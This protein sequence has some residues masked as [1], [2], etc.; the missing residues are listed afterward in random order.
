MYA[1]FAALGLLA[2][3]SGLDNGL[4]R[5]PPIGWLNWERYR[6]NTNCKDDPNNCINADLFLTMAKHMAYDGY[7]DVGYEYVNIDDCW[8]ERKRDA[9]NQLVSNPDLFPNGVK[10]L[11][12]E[13]HDLGLK[14]GIY[15]DYGTHTC[16][17]YPGSR[18]HV[19]DDANLFASWGIDSLKLDGCY[20]NVTE[21]PTGYPEFTVA[22]NKTGRPIL[23][24]CSWPAYLRNKDTVPYGAIAENCNLWRNYGDIADSWGSVNAIANW[25]G[26]NAGDLAS[27][28]APGAW[29]D[30]DMLIIGD[31][32]LSQ[33]QS[34]AQMALWSIMAAPLYMSNDLRNIQ[35]WQ[36]DILQNQEVIMVDQDPLGIQGRRIY[37]AKNKQFEI[38]TRQLERGDMAICFFRKDGNGFPKHFSA[39]FETLGI[40]AETIGLRDLYQHRNIGI[41]SGKISAVV[42][43]SGSVRMFRAKMNPTREQF[44][45]P[46]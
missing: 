33:G 45:I 6:C 40:K 12:D 41:F 38:W 2:T 34:E 11:A 42:N 1:L 27:F 44:P 35:Q 26:N 39:T 29:N 3:V 18:G 31:Y 43:P 17:G 15:E 16:G 24:S 32:G 22:L 21:F 23:Y 14:I 28:A 25:F 4:A 46:N 20:C 9:N 19:Q 5:T 7:K 10:G 37:Q 13:I 30:P 8:M 36:K